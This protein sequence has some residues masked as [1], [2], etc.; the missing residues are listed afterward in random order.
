MSLFLPFLLLL[1]PQLSLSFEF[2][3]PAPTTPP[4]PIGDG[5]RSPTA[6]SSL[7]NTLD[8]DSSGSLTPNE[9]KKFI[10]KNFAAVTQLDEEAEIGKA[11]ESVLESVDRHDDGSLSRGE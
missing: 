3:T 5:I 8:L 9:I 11:V 10:R 4:S 2:F 1:I 6:S 7:F